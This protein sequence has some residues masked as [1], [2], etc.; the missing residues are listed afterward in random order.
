[1]DVGGDSVAF[2]PRCLRPPFVLRREGS[3]DELR[4][5][6]NG[7]RVIRKVQPIFCY[8]LCRVIITQPPLSHLS[9]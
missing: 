1:M 5:G 9:P 2:A 4:V 8:Q 3:L 7:E 6:L